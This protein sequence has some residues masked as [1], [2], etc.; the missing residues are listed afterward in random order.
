LRAC[1]HDEAVF[2]KLA[3][4][5]YY[6]WSTD[7]PDYMMMSED[8]GSIGSRHTSDLIDFA[9]LPDDDPLA[10]VRLY[11]D[12]AV[13]W[14]ASD[15]YCF[16]ETFFGTCAEAGL[17]DFDQPIRQY[18]R[19]EELYDDFSVTDA[20]KYRASVTS[21]ATR[22]AL[23]TAFTTRELAELTPDLIFAFGN[24][25]W[26]VLANELTLTPVDGQHDPDMGITK[27][28]GQLYT[29]QRLID[30]DVLPLLHMSG[31]AFGAQRTPD[32]Y[33]DRLRMG[34]RTWNQ[35]S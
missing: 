14:L 10:Q 18:I 7:T 22:A 20:N 33:A 5:Y 31:Q 6:D 15:N 3:F 32:E 25:A 28:D 26:E 35:R 27:F 17:I 24:D 16:S 8:P 9:E 11:R 19:N 29:S 13:R 23:S 21:S 30:T 2:R 1:L 12:F 34:L 4:T